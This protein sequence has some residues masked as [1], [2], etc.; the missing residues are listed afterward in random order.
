MTICMKF[1]PK[2]PAQ[3]VAERM[4]CFKCSFDAGTV[5]TLRVSSRS[6]DVLSMNQLPFLLPLVRDRASCCQVWHSLRLGPA[7]LHQVHHALLCSGY[8]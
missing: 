6:D 8:L 5:H 2:K 4:H 1:G 3:K 7:M